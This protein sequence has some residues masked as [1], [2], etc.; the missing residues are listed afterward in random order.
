VTRFVESS[1]RVTL[2]APGPRIN[3]MPF[4]DVA[5]ALGSPAA[6]PVHGGNATPSR[7]R[8][9]ASLGSRPN[10]RGCL[11]VIPLSNSDGHFASGQAGRKELD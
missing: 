5:V 11:V 6:S 4:G 10:L 8:R 9:P 1:D 2:K 3:G 7:C